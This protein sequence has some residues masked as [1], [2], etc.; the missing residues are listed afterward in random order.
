AAPELPP[1]VV[2]WKAFLQLKKERNM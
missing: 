1:E 2:K